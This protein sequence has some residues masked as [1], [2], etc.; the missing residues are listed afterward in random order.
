MIK[1]SLLYNSIREK[2]MPHYFKEAVESIC[3]SIR[4]DSSLAQHSAKMPFGKGA[5]D[6]LCHFLSLAE[7]LGFETHNYDGYVGEVVFGH[8]EPFAIL[9]HLDVVP[10]GDGWTKPPFGGIVEDGKIWGRGA[11]DDKGPA[12]CTLYALKAL[13]DR[14]FY[15]QKQIKLI[16]GCNEENGWGCIDYYEKVATLPETGFSPDADFPVIYAEKGILHVRLHYPLPTAPFYFLE[17]GTSANMVCDTCEAT[18]R[19]LGTKRLLSSGL[20][21]RG[22]KLISH[23]KSA[24]GSTPEK[25]VNAIRPMLEYFGAKNETIRKIV[26][27]L[28]DDRFGLKELADETGHLTLSPDLIKYRKGELQIVCDIR[29]PATVPVEAVHEKLLK[30]GVKYETLHHQAPLYHDKNSELVQTLLSVYEAC[31]GEKADPI[32]IGGGTYARAL[33][34]GV[35][36]GPEME[37]DEAVIHQPDEYITLDRVDLLLNVYERAIEKLTK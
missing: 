19:S 25:G 18:P 4:F 13:K 10:A 9:C 33:K 14:G 3:E 27:D 2:F 1:L 11:M 24:H 17:G 22:K 34:N 35:G 16:V 6:C 7:K 31:T 5:Y 12:I 30:L 28:F 15:P 37:G 20:E 23:G 26:S 32:A 36:F 21:I 29:Y 8:G